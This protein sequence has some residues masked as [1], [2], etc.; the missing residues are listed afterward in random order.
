MVDVVKFT[1]PKLVW[2][3]LETTGLNPDEGVILEIGVIVTDLLLNELARKS[4][5]LPYVRSEVLVKMDDYVLNMH[6][7]SGLL[8]E[9]WGHGSIDQDLLESKRRRVYTD[10][11]GWIRT[12]CKHTRIKHCHLSG[13][14]VGTF[15]MAWLRKHA[16]GISDTFSYRVGDVSTFKV[17]FPNTLS[18]PA[19]GPAHR[20]LDD[21][22]Y[23]IDQLRQMRKLLGLESADPVVVKDTLG[24]ALM[25]GL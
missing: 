19:G 15:D 24:Q 4:W 7:K 5:V 3:D 16:P 12:A 13:S 2:L 25:E 8:K 20:A 23:S 11:A 17:F 22:D 9:V 18:Q 6:L 1:E 10:V 14:S 21:L